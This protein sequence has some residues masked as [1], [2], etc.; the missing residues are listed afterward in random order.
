MNFNS[1]SYDW[2]VIAGAKAQYKGTGVINGSGEYKFILTAVDGQVPGG[3][4]NDK[5][6][7]K[8]WDKYTDQ[9][10][11]DNKIGS[12]DSEL[13]STELGGGSIVIHN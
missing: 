11:Y 5:I 3:G 12:E 7:I 10:I 2:L 8:I 1:T 4:G 13:P 9:L 6:R